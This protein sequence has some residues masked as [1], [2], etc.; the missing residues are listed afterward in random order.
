ML[1]EMCFRN[2]IS[3]QFDYRYCSFVLIFYLCV[4]CLQVAVALQVLPYQDIYP[5]DYYANDSLGSW[6]VNNK[7]NQPVRG[8][9]K[10]ITVESERVAERTECY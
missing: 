8:R 3:N 7:L 1:H 2:A 4:V 9:R 6:T 5:M 10:H